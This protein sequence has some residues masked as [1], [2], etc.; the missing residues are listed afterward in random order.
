MDQE[1]RCLDQVS[2]FVGLARRCVR[3]LFKNHN[4]CAANRDVRH[5]SHFVLRKRTKNARNAQ[6]DPKNAFPDPHVFV[7][8]ETRFLDQVSRSCVFGACS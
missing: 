3:F 4:L 1:T 7:D 5:I 2:F 6:P 8:Q